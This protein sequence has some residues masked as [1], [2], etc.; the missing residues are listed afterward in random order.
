MSTLHQTLA[1]HVR[2]AFPALARTIDGQP[3]AYFD[4]P[5]GTQVPRCVV[6][7]MSDY[8]LNHNAND[9]WAFRTSVETDG[10]LQRARRAAAEFIRAGSTGEVLFGNN[11]TTLAFH[12]AR[13]VGRSLR[14]GDEIIVTDLDHNANVDPWVALA[15]DYG[16][17]IRRVPLLEN[18]P[19]LDFAAYEALLGPRT[20]LVAIGV[21]SN[22]F[23]TINP[24]RAI[25]DAAHRAGAWVFVDAVHAAAHAPLDVDELGADML[26]FSAYKVYGPHV[27]VAYCR[28]ALLERLEFPRLAPQLPKGSKRAESGTLNHEGIVGTGA[29]IEF[30]A[31][32]SGAGTEPLRD[33]IVMTMERLAREEELVFAT[34]VAGLRA[35]P[36]VH[37][38]EPPSGVPRHPTVA[39]RIDGIAAADVSRRLSDEH[40]LMVSHG[41]FYAATA[42]PQIVGSPA[43]HDG[44]VR[45]GLALYSS[46]DDVRRLIDAVAACSASINR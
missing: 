38:Y 15:R 9:G 42:V 13:A 1:E 20:K 28:D 23:G 3:V 33:R 10:A 37:L 31:S 8:L 5:G 19:R 29:A 30:L 7:A 21:S 16:A 6:D 25:A 35:L 44:V 34:L 4:G 27:G 32:L 11:M 36:G 12:V 22:A 18:Q 26:A 14:P 2:P 43:A 17:V 39:F 24:V 40:A 46:S 41:N 45:A